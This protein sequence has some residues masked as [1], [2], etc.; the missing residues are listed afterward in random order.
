[1]FPETVQRADAHLQTLYL[2]AVRMGR[3]LWRNVHPDDISRSWEDQLLQ[4]VPRITALQ[5]TAAQIG[6]SYTGLALADQGVYVPPS[7]FVDTSGLAGIAPSGAPLDAALYSVVPL[8]KDW[9]KEGRQPGQA[10][11][12]GQRML[13]MQLKTIV[14]DTSRVAA[15]MDVATRAHVSWCRMLNRPSCGRCI[16]LAGRIYRWNQGFLRHPRCDCRHIPVTESVPDQTTDPYEAFR[17][18][19]EEQQA[20]AFTKAGAQ[21][22]RDG[23]DIHQVGNS[24]RGM[25]YAGGTAADGTFRGR[26]GSLTTLSGTGRR[27]IHDK[28][29]GDRLT[30]E[31][32][33][34]LGLD[35]AQT[36]QMLER[37]SYILPGGQDPAGVLVG[38]RQGYGQ[39][40]RGGARVGT[41]SAVAEARRT[42]VRRPGE[43]ATMTAAE[44]RHQDVQLRW[45]AVRQGRNPFGKGQI[46]PSMAAA[47]EADYRRIVLGNDQVAKLTTITALRAVK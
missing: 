44:R 39:L 24:R 40:G 37:H 42:G 8:V 30:P 34:S 10:L 33:Y 9:I 43:R 15:G 4:L 47:V 29:L 6:S 11:Q 14:A 26:R 23:A 2:G 25:S 22:I 32:I 45:D 18:M 16:L 36:L 13:D 12:M 7:S 31:G 28:R 1:M 35:R 19:T 17:S 21:A 5:I 27:G 3:R 20:K 41:S 46:S 38:Q